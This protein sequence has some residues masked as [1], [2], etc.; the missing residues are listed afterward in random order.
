[1]RTKDSEKAAKEAELRSLE[2]QTVSIQPTLDG[3]NKIL[4]SF[5]FKSFV[6]AKGADGKTY[7][8]IR[9]DGTDAQNSLSEGE[10]NFVTFLYFYYLLK[11]SQTESGMISDKVVV[12]D[13]PVSS[14]D[15][16]VLFIV[17]SLIRELFNDVMNNKG[18]I[19]QI[20]VL[21]HN[22]YF[23]KEV[24]FKSKQNKWGNEETFWLIKKQVANSIVERQPSNPIKTS[25]QL[26]W[27]EV[28]SE[29]RNNATIRNTLRRI[30]ENY[31][32]L[33]GNISLEKLY[34][35]FEGD[36]K[37]KCKA[38]CSWVNDGSHSVFEDEYYTSLDATSVGRYL[39]VFRQ[40]FEKCNQIPHN[41]MMMEIDS[42]SKQ[43][44]TE[45][46][47]NND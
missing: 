47:A 38:L 24:T 18:T 7:K 45:E 3:I 11:G 36:D 2:K 35:K 40:I 30:L 44:F 20:F 46:A 37:I 8:L 4:A 6:L 9:G 19:K 41:N 14:L 33:L 1:M 28:R 42:E 31:F 34:T 39:D 10:R 27:S 13:D 17:S 23:H 16:D 43:D 15:S 29:H 26:L 32:K 22:V 12:F 25:Y 5:G 21:T